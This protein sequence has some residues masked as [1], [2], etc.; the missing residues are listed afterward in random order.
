MILESLDVLHWQLVL[1]SHSIPCLHFKL[2]PRLSGLLNECCPCGIPRAM[3][4]SICLSSF[5]ARF[6][7]KRE[8]TECVRDAA[9]SKAGHSPENQGTAQES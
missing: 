5:K 1:N 3:N 2:L 9:K 7:G 6:S 8:K 4:R